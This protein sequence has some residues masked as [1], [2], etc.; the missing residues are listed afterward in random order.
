[1]TV[2]RVPE[3]LIFKGPIS[4][5]HTVWRSPTCYKHRYRRLCTSSRP[6]Q[7][8]RP[9]SQGTV[10]KGVP[11]IRPLKHA[12]DILTN[13]FSRRPS[14]AQTHGSS[15]LQ[16]AHSCHC[17]PHAAPRPVP[18]PGASCRQHRPAVTG[19]AQLAGVWGGW[20]P[21]GVAGLRGRAA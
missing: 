6:Q 19:A 13:L 5:H 3:H 4:M 12:M 11:F 1:M 14:G 18:L 2:F 15:I 20:S 17:P 7:V 10:A 9:P 21:T 8:V 16:S